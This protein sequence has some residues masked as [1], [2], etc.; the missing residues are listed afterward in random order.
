MIGRRVKLAVIS[1]VLIGGAAWG[2]HKVYQ[3]P[4]KTLV[5]DIAALR[6]SI[7]GLEQMIDEVRDTKSRLEAVAATTLGDR[8][9]EVEARFRSSL[10]EIARHTGLTDIVANSGSPRPAMNPAS[11]ARLR[12]EFGTLLKKGVDF[13]MIDGSL[14]GV[15]T[16]DQVLAVLAT[17]QAQPWA[18]RVGGVT[19]KPT[20]PEDAGQF[21]MRLDAITTML[22]P[23]IVDPDSPG[24]GWRPLEPHESDRWA[25][26]VQKNIFRVPRAEAPPVVAQPEVTPEPAKPPYHEWRLTGLPGGTSGQVAGM[27]NSRTGE[28]RL[29]E[30]GDQVLDAQLIY[31]DR[32]STV[33]EIAGVRYEVLMGQTLADRREIEE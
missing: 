7:D 5:D 20:G 9:A 13:Y 32:F 30:E 22:M 28:S 12:G 18:H 8:Q 17:V 23:E 21:E 3:K 24:P 10:G 11:A 16:L 4:R 1:V 25:A 19:I 15:G 2:F 26:I 27:T 14:S 29:L 6:S 33:F 31:I